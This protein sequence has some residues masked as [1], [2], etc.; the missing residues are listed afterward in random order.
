MDDELERLASEK[1]GQII[2]ELAAGRDYGEVLNVVNLALQQHLNSHAGQLMCSKLSLAEPLDGLHNNVNA[3]GDMV[4]EGFR[5]LGEQMHLDIESMA[6]T[7]RE[8]SGK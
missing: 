5:R 3:L 7:L 1:I 4:A 2:A 8:P 6:K